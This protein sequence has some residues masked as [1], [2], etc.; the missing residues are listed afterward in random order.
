[1]GQNF[2]AC[3]LVNV[4][5][6]ALISARSPCRS[7][8]TTFRT[9]SMAAAGIAA[10]DAA[11][12]GGAVVWATT[13]RLNRQTEADRVKKLRTGFLQVS[14]RGPPSTAHAANQPT[15]TAAGSDRTAGLCA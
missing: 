12:G 10:A 2:A 13:E 14:V 8:R 4:R 9:S 7:A 5:F 11:V 15:A 3:S 6:F 1:M